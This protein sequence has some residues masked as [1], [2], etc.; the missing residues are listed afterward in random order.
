VRYLERHRPAACRG[1][2]KREGFS[3][4]DQALPIKRDGR[5][6]ETY[7]NYSFTP[8]PRRGRR[9][10]GVF[11]QAHEITDRVLGERRNQFLWR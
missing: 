1:D 8:D 7:W 6:G 5:V 2:A 10:L 4:F 3:T 11:T 9:C